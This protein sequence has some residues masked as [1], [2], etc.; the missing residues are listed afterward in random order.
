MKRCSLTIA[1]SLAA[2]FLV[3]THAHADGYR[4]PPAEIADIVL[5]PPAPSVSVSPNGKN[6]LLLERES[7]P[8]ISELAKSMER[9]AGQRLDAATNDNFNPRNFVGL[10]LKD[11]DSG[12]IRKVALPINADIADQSWSPDGRYVVFTNTTTE[13]M[14][15][16]TLDTR[17]AKASQILKDGINPIFKEP[18]WLPDGR[19]LVLTIPKDRGDKPMASLTPSGPA[20]QDASGGQNAQTRTY[21]DLLK[22]PHDEALYTWLVESQ[23][24]VMHPDGSRKKN[25]GAPR[26]YID[27]SASPSGNYLLMEWINEPF[28]Y[29]VPWSRFPRTTAVWTME[30][31]AVTVIT[32][33]PLADS[34]P[35]QGVV[36]GPRKIEWHPTAPATL[37][38]AEAQDGGDPRVET[39]HRDALMTLSSPFTGE[40]NRLHVF[41]DRYSRFVG[42]DGDDD[43]IAYDY[44]RDTREVRAALIDVMGANE[45]RIIEVRNVQDVYAHPG[46]PVRTLTES[47]FS[48][49]RVHEGQLFLSGNGATPDGARPF[50]RRFDLDTFETTELWRNTGE[51]YEYVVDLAAD[52]GS[53]FVTYYESPSLPGNY[54]LHNADVTRFL[55]DF[56]DPHPELTDISRELITYK[57]KDGVELSS[58]L[59]LPAGY[60]EGD[61]LPVVVW[62]YPREFNDAATAGQVRDSKYRFT[63]IGG[64]SHLFFLTQGYA[65]MDR[66]AMP[67]VGSDPETVNDTFIDQVVDS[68]QAAVD[69]SVRRG[70]GD[71]EQVGVGGHS[72]GAFMT[73]HLLARSDI[74]RAGIARSGAY[75]RTLTPF[76]FQAER[77][78]FWDAPETYYKL[79]PFMAAN[80]INE[81]MLMLHG[82]KDNNSGTFPQQSERMFAAIKGTGGT[83]RLVMLPHES[84]GYRSRESVLHTLAEMVDWFETHVK[85]AKPAQANG[86]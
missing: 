8:P 79:S 38:W 72:Y 3:T 17:T 56:P 70:F 10:S 13:G 64:Y 18:R 54:R 68:A 80:L 85:S 7:L 25:L 21:Q 67:V 22:T 1:A 12:V 35:V 55:T 51:E 76:G 53:A 48:V 11:I 65:V 75:N 26:I 52:D 4:L 19:L 46:S 6:L 84:H 15:V 34:L 45:P 66:A 24:M 16:W 9:L 20:I 29:Q 33:Q 82:A 60:E 69:E 32:E 50:L 59:Y 62:A 81:P 43:I 47:G 36:M 2:M 71:G 63:R 42:L 28:S 78:I 58:T 41:E 77:R 40:A 44:D 31:E 49:A 27:A 23:P 61:K 57:R 14:S 74:F 30:G 37:L 5:R 83:A 39:D 86:K 73:A